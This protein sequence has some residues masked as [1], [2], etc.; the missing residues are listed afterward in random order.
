MPP[1]TKP[2]W[3]RFLVFLVPLMVSNILQALSGTINNI[4]IGQLIGVRAL[5][6][7]SVFFPIMIFLISFII[8]LASGATI[9]IGQAWGGK[10]SRRSRKSPAR[11]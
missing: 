8:G 9:L 2:L 4:Y 6:A 1:V 5:A 10:T 3:Q 11:R 7:V